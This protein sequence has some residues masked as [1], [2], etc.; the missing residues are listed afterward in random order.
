[1]KKLGPK[2]WIHP[3]CAENRS[4]SGACEMCGETLQPNSPRKKK[5][6]TISRFMTP[7][8]KR[9][10]NQ[11]QCQLCG[12]RYCMSC[13]DKI[14]DTMKRV[15][16]NDDRW[17]HLKCEE[18]LLKR[19]ISSRSQDREWSVRS[20]RI[21][22]SLYPCSHTPGMV[23]VTRAVFLNEYEDEHDTE[24]QCVVVRSVR[25]RSARI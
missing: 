11:I 25:A 6:N 15:Q 16:S 13:Y 23:L 1:M 3:R 14:K 10:R 12:V 5:M 4:L 9:V 17:I 22:G 7:R 18:R 20:N 24:P 19:Q 2:R 21:S 8:K